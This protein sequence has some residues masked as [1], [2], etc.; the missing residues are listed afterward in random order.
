MNFFEYVY[1]YFS[2][3]GRRRE[4]KHIRDLTN[5]V[6]LVC[7]YLSG[8]ITLMENDRIRGLKQATAS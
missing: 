7:C 3:E 4:E 2:G 6:T 1:D 8:C 5:V